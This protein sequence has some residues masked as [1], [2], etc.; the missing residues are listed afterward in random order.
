MAFGH[1]ILQQLGYANWIK[2]FGELDYAKRSSTLLSGGVKMN[3]HATPGLATLTFPAW[4]L[5][6]IRE[7]AELRLKLEDA[8]TRCAILGAIC[9]ERTIMRPNPVHQSRESDRPLRPATLF[10]NDPACFDWN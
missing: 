6:L 8:E 3:W 4:V 7:R 1:R 2:P 9:N 5:E 10:R